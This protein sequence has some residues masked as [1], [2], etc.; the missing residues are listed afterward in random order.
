MPFFHRAQTQ[1]LHQ[2]LVAL[3]PMFP[4]QVDEEEEAHVLAPERLPHPFH[5]AIN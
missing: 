2:L 3:L 1:Q 4:F 5:V